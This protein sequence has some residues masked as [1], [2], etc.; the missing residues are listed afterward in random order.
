MAISV[1]SLE[2][3]SET[4]LDFI[5]KKFDDNPNFHIIDDRKRM[6]FGKPKEYFLF[7][8]NTANGLRANLEFTFIWINNNLWQFTY[9]NTE[10]VNKPSWKNP[11]DLLNELLNQ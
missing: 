3:I 6:A 1:N 7:T 11:L 8:N 5:K 9:C 2:N 10:C 4:M